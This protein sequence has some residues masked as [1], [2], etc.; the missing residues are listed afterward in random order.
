MLTPEQCQGDS[1]KWICIYIN[2]MKLGIIP[3]WY[4]DLR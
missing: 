3:Q 2:A 1:N 4:Q